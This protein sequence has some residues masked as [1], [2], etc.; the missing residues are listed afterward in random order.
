M[1]GM[2][3]Y[4]KSPFTDTPGWLT[5]LARMNGTS[6]CWISAIVLLTAVVVS[7]EEDSFP[8][9]RLRL[10]KK[11]C[12]CSITFK[13]KG[14]KV[15]KSSKATCDKKCSGAGKKLVLTNNTTRTVF[16]FGIKVKKGKASLIKPSVKVRN[17][18]LLL[19][20]HH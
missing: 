15:M 1:Q 6:L 8:G 11:W 16:S 17:E 19:H 9:V 12:L 10:G 20:P 14:S 13:V 4:S 3:H 2:L 7:S 5:Q 18:G